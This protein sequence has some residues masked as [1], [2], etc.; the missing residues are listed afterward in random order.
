MQK[1]EWFK[2][3]PAKFL[4]D[5]QVDAMST[6]ELG[7]CFRLLCR[8]WIDG[9]IA[10]DLRVLARL[11]RLDDSRMA[12][13]WVTLADFFPVVEPGRRANRFMWIEREKVVADLE[14]KSD[15]GTRA[16]RKRWDESN[17]KRNV[18][19]NASP[20][21]RPNGS[22]MPDPMQEQSRADQSG[23][24]DSSR[25]ELLTATP[26]SPTVVS[27]PCCGKG[28]REYAVTEQE[29]T[30]WSS[31]FPGVNCLAEARKMA[32]WLQK[33]PRKK[34]TFTGMGKFIS[35]W[36]SKAQNDGRNNQVFPVEKPKLTLS[37]VD[38]T[39]VAPNP[40]MQAVMKTWHREPAHAAGGDHGD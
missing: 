40:K 20:I 27:L 11:C 17:R 26:S 38:T 23:A 3:D 2:M 28:P 7:A 8:Q 37:V 12:E 4:F 34:K 1:P 22:G 14:K 18:E 6:L 21:A 24:E 13:A 16:A 25:S 35:N 15:E 29:L 36:L 10:D 32:F 19:P 5:A 33:N 39:P 9:T 31:A 30:E